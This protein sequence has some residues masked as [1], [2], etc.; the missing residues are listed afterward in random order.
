MNDLG[1]PGGAS[2]F[3]YPDVARHQRR[4][5][6][7]LAGAGVEIALHLNGLR[8]SRL[9]GPQ[10][11]W[12]GE[13]SFQEQKEA[14]RLAKQDIED[15]IGQPCLG[16]RACYGSAN[17]N[18]FPILE[19]L[20][21]QW[22]SNCSGRHRP[23]FCANWAGSWPFAHHANRKCKLVPGDMRLCEIPVTVGLKTCYQGNPDQPLDLRVETPPGILGEQREQLREVIRE[24]IVEM[25]RRAIPVRAIIG[26]SHNTN[27][28]AD[29]ATHQS[30]NLDW[31]VRHTRELAAQ[32]GLDFSPARFREIKEEADR[33]GTY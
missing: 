10:A 7:E 4:L 25:A 5:Y 22:A 15:A 13:M 12:L 20:G 16:Y 31:V 6:R 23:E 29:R 8:Y 33:I 17:D 14:L 32:H 21:F 3:V 28:Y 1:A 18:T 2:L 30:Q 27:P 26:G 11:K 19:E 9:R 24:N